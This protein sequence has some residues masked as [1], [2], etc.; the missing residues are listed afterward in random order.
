MC[1]E[2]ILRTTVQPSILNITLPSMNLT[3]ASGGVAHLCIRQHVQS[4]SNAS[5]P[6]EIRPQIYLV[7]AQRSI[8]GRQQEG[9]FHTP[10]ISRT[11]LSSTAAPQC[12]WFKPR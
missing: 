4:G 7:P 8:L 9:T 11:S 2:H 3:V 5:L 6:E 10:S 12:G 1:V